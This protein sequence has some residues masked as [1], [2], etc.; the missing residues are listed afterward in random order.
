MRKTTPINPPNPATKTVRILMGTCTKGI[1]STIN[2]SI[3]PK[4]TCNNILII[5]PAALK[6]IIKPTAI[7]TASR[8]PRKIVSITIIFPDSYE[9]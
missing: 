7:I 9:I 1:K 8:I 2:R 3:R 6:R 4:T 5:I